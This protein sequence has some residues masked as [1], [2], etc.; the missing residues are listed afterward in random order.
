MIISTMNETYDIHEL[1][2]LTII[3]Q[4]FS[5]LRVSPPTM[6][7]YHVTNSDSTNRDGRK[8]HTLLLACL[9]QKRIRMSIA[10]HSRSNSL[11][12][13]GR[14]KLARKKIAKGVPE[15]IPV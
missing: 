4:L 11:P 10:T 2:P 15:R 3:V 13:S 8:A 14:C 5:L 12:C 6:H 7:P 1:G 9:I